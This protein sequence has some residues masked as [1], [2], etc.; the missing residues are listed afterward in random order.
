MSKFNIHDHVGRIKAATS[1]SS[2]NLV[3]FDDILQN[4]RRQ[5]SKYIPAEFIT[6]DDTSD[7]V[8]SY[9]LN[10]SH[11]K[12]IYTEM[13]VITEEMFNNM[14]RYSAMMVDLERREEEIKKK[15]KEFKK[16]KNDLKHINELSKNV[17]QLFKG[18]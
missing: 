12:T 9:R 4:S 6:I 14:T 5:L 16:L 8:M 17:N 3:P 10:P 11:T 1:Y 7:E 13:Y 18:L 2:Y 15:E